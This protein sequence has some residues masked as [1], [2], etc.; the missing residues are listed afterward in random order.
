MCNFNHLSNL[1]FKT[2]EIIRE[3]LLKLANLI[4]IDDN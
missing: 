4:I 1:Q 3:K 2:I